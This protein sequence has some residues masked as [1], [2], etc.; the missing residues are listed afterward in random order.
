MCVVDDVGHLIRGGVGAPRALTTHAGGRH[1]LEYLHGEKAADCI[2][3]NTP[4]EPE[5]VE[6]YKYR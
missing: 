5:T 3:G 4:L 2:L 6:F 1:R